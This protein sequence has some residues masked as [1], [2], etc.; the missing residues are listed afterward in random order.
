MTR[1]SFV[2]I[3]AGCALERLLCSILDTWRPFRVPAFP[4]RLALKH[5]FMLFAGSAPGSSSVYMYVSRLAVRAS[6][7][8]RQQLDGAF[9]LHVEP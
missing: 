3:S 1:F 7:P 6:A 5:L 2:S 8:L 4:G 9:L